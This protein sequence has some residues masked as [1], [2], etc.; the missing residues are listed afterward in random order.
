MITHEGL[1]TERVEEGVSQCNHHWV[2]GVA[3]GPTSTGVCRL[4][5]AERH[6]KNFLDGSDW[7]DEPSPSTPTRIL[8][9]TVGE[10]DDSEE[11]S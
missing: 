10:S 4:C 7:N 1:T 5:G 9:S 11:Q 8:V 2:I 3:S 6:F